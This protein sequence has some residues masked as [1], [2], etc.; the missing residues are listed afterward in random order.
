MRMDVCLGG[1]FN[2]IH[3][4]HL[5]MLDLAFRLGG[6]VYIGLTSDGM[7]GRTRERVL[8]Y[9]ARL[10]ALSGAC[11]RFGD[12]F[13]VMELDDPFGYSTVLR[14]LRGIVVSE[15]TTFRVQEINRIRSEKGFPPLLTYVVPMIRS[16]NGL[17]LSSTRVMSGECDSRGRLLHPL[18]VGI[19]SRN[20]TKVG[21]VRDAFALY[22][23]EIGD[24]RFSACKPRSGV[25]EQPF[26][27]ETIRGALARA[28]DARRENDLGVGIEA[29]L[30]S[31]K[32][33]DAVLDVQYCVIVDRVGRVTGGHGMGFAYPPQV[34]DDVARGMTIGD[35]MSRISGIKDIGTKRGAI[36]YLS[37]GKM[38]RRELTAQAV[39][40][41]LI[42]RIN[43][44][45]YS[46]AWRL[47]A[48]NG[49]RGEA[50]KGSGGHATTRKTGEASDGSAEGEI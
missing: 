4:G 37:H 40:S 30:F 31:S 12:N 22:A 41:A 50:R 27:T 49:A 8:P 36:G 21:A 38:S 42:P 17:P 34:L 28:R 14:G 5:S 2:R 13:E 3:A 44:A 24:A 23:R 47:P 7:A 25:P 29:G 33:L 15:A 32:E 1:T 11:R 20:G 10:R 19:G 16:F 45:L 9:G 39:L 18:R 43:P 6:R 48:Q 26:D 46:E 35:I